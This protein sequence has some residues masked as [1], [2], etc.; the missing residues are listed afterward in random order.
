[1]LA[2]AV[3][4]SCLSLLSACGAETAL[5]STP[6]S[7]STDPVAEAPAVDDGEPADDADAPTDLAESPVDEAPTDE[8]VVSDDEAP[9]EDAP[10]EPA[11]VTSEPSLYKTLAPSQNFDLSQW[12]LTLPSA[13]IVKPV[14][15]NSGYQYAGVFY[16]DTSNGGMAFRCP[17]RA[18]TTTNSNYSRTELREVLAPH[19][20]NY[21]SNA[22]NWKP[23]RGGTLKATL[24]IDKVSTTGE[25]KKVGRLVIGQIHDTDEPME[26]VRLHYVKKPTDAK[27]RLYAAF[28]TT[29]GSTSYSPDL[30]PNTNGNGIALGEKF[31]YEISL[32]GT[33][34]RVVIRRL[35]AAGA[36]FVASSYTKTVDSRYLGRNVYFKA[37][38]YSQNNTGD[39]ADYTQATYFALTH[40]HP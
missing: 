38:V 13:A 12:Y 19:D 27:G 34:L 21:K 18:G 11:P 3:S 40:T 20:N 33:K 23:E 2:A 15:L 17:N 28:E 26:V 24:R 5:T 39:L 8:V 6:S 29:G 31:R 35:D 9:I 36:W 10:A 22:N 16:T 37:G 25:D 14:E 30:I 7:A 1:M 32:T 4:F